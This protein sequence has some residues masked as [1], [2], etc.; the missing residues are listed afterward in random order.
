MI[1]PS[2]TALKA[3]ETPDPTGQT[4]S[5]VFEGNQTRTDS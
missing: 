4:R 3:I 2:V 5:A 1:N